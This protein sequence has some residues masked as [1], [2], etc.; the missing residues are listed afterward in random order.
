MRYPEHIAIV[1]TV[2]VTATEEKLQGR[3]ASSLSRLTRGLCGIFDFK[4]D[5]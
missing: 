2:F 1:I 3:T 5:E 4:G